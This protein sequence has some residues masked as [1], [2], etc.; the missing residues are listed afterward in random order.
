[1]RDEFVFMNGVITTETK[2]ENDFL[3]CYVSGKP[4]T[5]KNGRKFEPW[6]A[7][8]RFTSDKISEDEMKPRT[9]V[10]TVEKMVIPEESANLMKVESIRAFFGK[11]NLAIPDETVTKSDLIQVLKD[12]GYII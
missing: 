9:T 4:Y 7:T 10:T 12:N 6:L 5:L 2:E 11:V 1:M 8:C 3:D